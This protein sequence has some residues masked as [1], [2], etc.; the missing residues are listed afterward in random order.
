MIVNIPLATENKLRGSMALKHS[1]KIP[2][3]LY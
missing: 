3:F 2:F 1:T